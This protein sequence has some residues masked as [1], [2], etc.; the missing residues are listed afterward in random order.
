MCNTV[1][2]VIRKLGNSPEGMEG[3]TRKDLLSALLAD[4]YGIEKAE[5]RVIA[6]T[7]SHEIIPHPDNSADL[8][9][10]IYCPWHWLKWEKELNSVEVDPVKVGRDGRIVRLSARAGSA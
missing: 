3:F 9:I 7:A 1:P 10:S 5:R 6:V 2:N 8:W 4:G